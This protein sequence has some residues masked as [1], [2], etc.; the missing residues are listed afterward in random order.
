MGLRVLSLAV[1]LTLGVGLLACAE[2]E[3]MRAQNMAREA[4]A[5]AEDEATCRAKGEPGT[6]SYEECR[7]A[8]AAS[9]AER[10]AIQEQKRRDFDR[11]LGAG[12]DGLTD[13]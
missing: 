8:L 1:V 5:S 3:G 11:V 10:A 4:T 13:Y 7:K 9:R 6:E 2:R 12:T